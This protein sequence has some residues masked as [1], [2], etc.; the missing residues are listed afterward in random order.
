MLN[1]SKTKFPVCKSRSIL[2]P[3]YCP[4]S[5]SLLDDSSLSNK[6]RLKSN[7]A[8]PSKSYKLRQ[9]VAGRF[10]KPRNER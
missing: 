4:A 6:D 9:S 1:Q 8:V 2:Y 3:E 7:P 5:S 10:T